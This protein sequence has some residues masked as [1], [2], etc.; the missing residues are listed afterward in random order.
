MK[1]RLQIGKLAKEFTDVA[2]RVG[3]VIIDEKFLPPDASPTIPAADVG[4]AA[5]MFSPSPPSLS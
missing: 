2:A 4:G 1:L 3:K 5:G